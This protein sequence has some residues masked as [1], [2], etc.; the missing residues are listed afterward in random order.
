MRMSLWNAFHNKV[1][2]QL[3]VF[4]LIALHLV[5]QMAPCPFFVVDTSYRQNG[6]RFNGSLL[7][8]HAAV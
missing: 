5:W 6:V 1:A 2:D 3:T 4:H 8:M 7:R